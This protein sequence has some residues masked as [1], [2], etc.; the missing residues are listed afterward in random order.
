MA[1]ADLAAL[2]HQR[3]IYVARDVARYALPMLPDWPTAA[4]IEEFGEWLFSF[5]VEE[6]VD[7]INTRNHIHGGML[8]RGVVIEA[9]TV[10]VGAVHKIPGF[11]FSIG[12]IESW[13]T[14]AGR[15]RFTGAHFIRSVPGPRIVLAHSD[16][17]WFTVHPNLTGSED[18]AVIEDSIVENAELLMSRRVQRALAPLDQLVSPCLA[19]NL[20]TAIGPQ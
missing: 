5:P 1:A 12:D 7:D 10:V 16:T 2:D 3:L 15:Q 14:T 13:T 18:L 17:T 19:A 8:G 11:A 20:A 9:G 6:R 4:E